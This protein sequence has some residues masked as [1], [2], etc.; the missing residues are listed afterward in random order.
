MLK[1]FLNSNYRKDN[2]TTPYHRK[3]QALLRPLTKNRV[4]VLSF[5]ERFLYLHVLNL[6]SPYCGIFNQLRPVTF[7]IF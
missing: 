7:T 1:S 2:Q 5:N 6:K 3:K 4:K